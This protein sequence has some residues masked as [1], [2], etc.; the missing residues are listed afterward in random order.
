MKYGKEKTQS[1]TMFEIHHTASMITEEHN[2][3]SMLT[4]LEARQ[5][6]HSLAG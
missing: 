1:L 5:I 3:I 2:A 4:L 6:L